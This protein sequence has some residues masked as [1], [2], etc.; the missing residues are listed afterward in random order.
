[1]FAMYAVLEV[2]WKCSAMATVAYF[3]HEIE[4]RLSLFNGN[5]LEIN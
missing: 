4:L 1:M 3:V 5:Q 2:G